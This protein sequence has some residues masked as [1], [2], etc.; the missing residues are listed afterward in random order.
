M[1][2]IP[3]LRQGMPSVDLETGEAKQATYQR[4]DVTSVPAASVVGE[5]VVALALVEVFLEKYGGDSLEQVRAAFEFHAEQLR[6]I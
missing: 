6:E 3:S 5:A 2:P 1:K 4:S